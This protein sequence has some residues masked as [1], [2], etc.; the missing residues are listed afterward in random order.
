M[1]V[2]DSN[3]TLGLKAWEARRRA[4]TEP[5][6]QYLDKQTNAAIVA[7]KHNAAF[8]QEVQQRA[9]YKQLV[10]QHRILRT[11]ISLK[12]I[13]PILV[14][15]WQEDGVWPKGEIVQERSD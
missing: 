11:P 9:I 14:T 6:Q 2:E 1:A 4:W 15:G 8:K 12:Y 5:N 3:D 7:E 10:H 13:I